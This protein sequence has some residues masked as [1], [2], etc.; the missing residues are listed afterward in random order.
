M[1]DRVI[2][3]R[4][5]PVATGNYRYMVTVKARNKERL[6][7]QDVIDALDAAVLKLTEDVSDT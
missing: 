2:P 3:T 1:D 7:P 5:V 6:L 4:S